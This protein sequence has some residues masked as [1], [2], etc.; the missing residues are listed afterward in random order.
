MEGIDKI[1]KLMEEV[2]IGSYHEDG[3]ATN[4]EILW[5]EIIIALERFQE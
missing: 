4:P 3:G 1:W 5:V 2:T